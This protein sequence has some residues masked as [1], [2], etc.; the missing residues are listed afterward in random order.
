MVQQ[1]Q[2]DFHTPIGGA[3]Q[4]LDRDAADGPLVEAPSLMRAP[5][6]K[7]VLFFSSNC[8]STTAYDISYAFADNIRGPYEKKGPFAE[9]GWAS[10]LSAPG[11][12]DVSHDGQHALFHAGPV[13][14]R[15]LWVTGISV[16]E[17]NLVVNS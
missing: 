2:S 8:Y 16:D 1:V 3:T 6:G 4:I 15:A 11:G 9:T 5:G 10:G 12:L 13:G 7:Y 17:G 14:D